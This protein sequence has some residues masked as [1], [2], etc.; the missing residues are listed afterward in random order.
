MSGDNYEEYADKFNI[1]KLSRFFQKSGEYL[2]SKIY[3]FKP[4]YA[5]KLNFLGWRNLSYFIY[6][7]E[8]F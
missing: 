4:I 6:K 5:K 3:D 1:N 7:K 2:G 8:M